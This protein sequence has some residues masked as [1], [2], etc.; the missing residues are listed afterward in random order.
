[1]ILRAKALRHGNLRH[2]NT[3]AGGNFSRIASAAQS[4]RRKVCSFLTSQDGPTS[5]EYAVLIALAIALC[6]TAI[7]LVGKNTQNSFANSAKSVSAAV[8]GTP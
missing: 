1:M 8:K 5:V 3:I 7:G 6:L 4:S 2:S